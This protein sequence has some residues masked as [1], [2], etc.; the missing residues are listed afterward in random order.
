MRIK[1][2]VFPKDARSRICSVGEN[3]YIIQVENSHLT[4]DRREIS[5]E[6]WHRINFEE[7]EFS[8]EEEIVRDLMQ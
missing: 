3:G 4:T 5:T 2:A 1:L 8:Q 6:P 7:L